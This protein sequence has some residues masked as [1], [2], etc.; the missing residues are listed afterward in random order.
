MS[1]LYGLHF[2]SIFVGLAVWQT[3]GNVFPNGSLEPRPWILGPHR[4]VF[5][6][7]S[8]WSVDIIDV[9]IMPQCGLCRPVIFPAFQIEVMALPGCLADGYSSVASRDTGC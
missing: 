3:K 6:G 4:N 8:S 2:I 9:F 5:P 7:G 1:C